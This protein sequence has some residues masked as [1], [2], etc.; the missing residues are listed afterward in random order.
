MR[1]HDEDELV[2]YEDVGISGSS[3]EQRPGLQD[4]LREVCRRQG[5]LVVYA[6][7]R[8]A[9][10]TKDTLAKSKAELVS[11]SDRIDT[12]SASGKMVFRMLAVLAEFERDQVSERTRAAMG[13]L[14]P[15]GRRYSRFVPFGWDLAEGCQVLR[16]NPAKQAAIARMVERGGKGLLYREVA[17]RLAAEGSRRRPSRPPGPPTA[18][19]WPSGGLRPDAL[20]SLPTAEGD[21]REATPTARRAVPAG[22]DGTWS[23]SDCRGWTRLREQ[24]RPGV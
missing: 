20:G 1:L 11:L 13:H 22:T 19:G 3:M 24:A 2:F 12:T 10:S 9:R 21:P 15:S 23:P 4:A 6:L 14:R 5:V 16:P 17:H 7:W 8:L 18:P